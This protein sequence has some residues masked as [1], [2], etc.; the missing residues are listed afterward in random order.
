MCQIP[1]TSNTDDQNFHLHI[2]MVKF[3]SHQLFKL[4]ASE[5]CIEKLSASSVTDDFLFNFTHVTT[6]TS[7]YLVS[8]CLRLCGTDRHML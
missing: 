1:K 8:R 6:S 3:G 7:D 5:I 4:R 2:S